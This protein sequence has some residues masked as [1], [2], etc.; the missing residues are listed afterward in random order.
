[1]SVTVGPNIAGTGA[2]GGGVNTPWTNPGNITA[3]DA[4]F[5]V[6]SL[7]GA[8]THSN[9]LLATNFGFAIPLNATILGITVE[10]NRKRV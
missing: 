5:A 8:A 6:A 7:P 4:V 3:S 9:E 2:D 1:M 10:I